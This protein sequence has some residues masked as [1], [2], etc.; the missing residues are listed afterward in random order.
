MIFYVL[1]G[2]TSRITNRRHLYFYPIRHINMARQPNC[3]WVNDS[4]LLPEILGAYLLWIRLDYPLKL[5][6]RFGVTVG[7]GVFLYA[8]SAYGPG[9]IRARCS[10][11][12]K[13]D[14]NRRWHVD[15]LTTAAAYIDVLAFPGK[16]ECQLVSRLVTCGIDQLPVPGFGS[17][18]C[19][20]CQSHLISSGRTSQR[21]ILD[22]FELPIKAS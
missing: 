21:K 15:W 22:F 12:L 18:D 8:G 1:M 14:K 16:S 5:T 20:V 2:T 4:Q 17:S 10:R 9:G 11:H 6:R 19:K 13:D 7:P 3:H